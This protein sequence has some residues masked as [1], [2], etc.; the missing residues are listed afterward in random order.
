[1]HHVPPM[2]PEPE[3]L[4]RVFAVAVMLASVG[5]IAAGTLYGAPF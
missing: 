2:P 4:P 1:M 3:M 5:L